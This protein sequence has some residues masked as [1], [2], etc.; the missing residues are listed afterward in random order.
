VHQEL[1][2]A[3]IP[4]H[5]QVPEAAAAGGAQWTVVQPADGAADAALQ[6]LDQIPEG[7]IT[8]NN[9]MPRYCSVR[10]WAAEVLVSP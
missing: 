3:R 7:S 8:A 1:L 10:T 9:A 2:A 6:L 5:H 4:A